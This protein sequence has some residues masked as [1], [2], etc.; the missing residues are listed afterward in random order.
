MQGKEG[1]K[2][3]ALT[4]N[5]IWSMSNLCRSKPPPDTK[6]T[7]RAIPVLIDSLRNES[8][9]SCLSDTIWA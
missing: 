3:Q 8:D 6:L 2:A 9:L 5:I 7:K 1:P 4:K